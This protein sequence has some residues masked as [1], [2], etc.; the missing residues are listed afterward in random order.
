MIGDGAFT[1]ITGSK[2]RDFGPYLQELLKTV[3]RIWYDLAHPLAWVDFP[4]QQP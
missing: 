2:G 3:K 4:L 1:L